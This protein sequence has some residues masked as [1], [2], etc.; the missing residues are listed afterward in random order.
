MAIKDF[1][2]SQDLLLGLGGEDG[3]VGANVR[4]GHTI[5]RKPCGAALSSI[6]VMKRPV[7]VLVGLPIRQT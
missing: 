7:A 3:Q 6:G 4:E 2:S 5:M 1:E